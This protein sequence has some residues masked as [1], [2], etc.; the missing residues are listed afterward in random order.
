MASRNTVVFLLGLFLSS[1]TMSNAARML[2]E[3]MALSKGE[4]HQP[5]LPTLP[6]VELPPKPEMP[7]IPEFHFPKPE[8]KP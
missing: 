7:V 2:E 4:E 5:E 3:E 8:A 6:K 1:V